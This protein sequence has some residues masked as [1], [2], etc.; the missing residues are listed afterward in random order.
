MENKVVMTM[1]KRENESMRV[2]PVGAVIRSSRK[3][4]MDMAARMKKTIL[5]NSYT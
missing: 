5:P 3:S 4:P 2:K 1:Q